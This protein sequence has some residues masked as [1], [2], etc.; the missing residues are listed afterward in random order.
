MRPMS[1]RRAR[2]R[3]RRWPRADEPVIRVPMALSEF[4]VAVVGAGAA[5]L[6]PP[7]AFAH[8]A[9]PLGVRGIFD[10]TASLFRP[11]PVAFAAEEIGLKAF[12]WNVERAALVRHL[13]EAAAAARNLDLI[14]SFATGLQAREEVAELSL[15]SGSRLTCR[16]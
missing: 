9:A 5:G 10:D 12:G 11:P 6:S 14:P 15:S 7:T 13:S 4:D 16:L 1:R 8:G 3:A 2:P